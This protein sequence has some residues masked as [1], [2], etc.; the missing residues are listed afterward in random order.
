MQS[1]GHVVSLYPIKFLCLAQN[2]LV[3]ETASYS[4][5]GS[6]DQHFHLDTPEN[7]NG[8]FQIQGRKSLLHKF[9]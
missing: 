7:D 2:I 6:S 5:L 1:I 3:T 9:G 8:H 4:V